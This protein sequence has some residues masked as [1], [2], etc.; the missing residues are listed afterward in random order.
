MAQA[1]GRSSSGGKITCT[2]PAAEEDVEFPSPFHRTDWVSW[3]G[4]KAGRLWDT[5]AGW[6]RQWPVEGAWVAPLGQGAPGSLERG[7]WGGISCAEEP[8][9]AMCLQDGRR[10]NRTK[11]GSLCDSSGRKDSRRGSRKH[12]VKPKATKTEITSRNKNRS[13]A[14]APFR[15]T[16]GEM[17]KDWAI[18]CL[19]V[20]LAARV[21]A[22]LSSSLSKW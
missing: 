13:V 12:P 3:H 10:D 15:L 8:R 4:G 16:A 11:P 18:A 7:L 14:P 1:P 9:P 20:G 6:S 17:G 5:G 2:S 22:W 21:R 19:V